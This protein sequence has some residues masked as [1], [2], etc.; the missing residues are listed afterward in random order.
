MRAW[1]LAAAVTALLLLP[2]HAPAE[3]TFREVFAGQ[4][5]P[6]LLVD[7]E[8]G[9]IV[10][11]NPAAVRFYQHPLEALRLMKIWDV[12]VLTR[13][14]IEDEMRLAASLG[15]NFFIFR[16][17]L[18]SG[19]VRSVAV[20]SHPY[21]FDGRELLLSLVFDV[22]ALRQSGDA[23]WHYQGRLEEQIAAQVAELVAW[24]RQWTRTLAAAVALQLGLILFLVLTIRKRRQAE[25]RRERL[26]ARLRSIN[27]E[28]GRLAEVTA[29]HFQE[30]ARRLVTFARSLR[31][32]L[33]DGP[34]PQEAESSLAFIEQQAIHLRSL[35]RDLQRFLAAG[36]P[37]GPLLTA[38][39]AA[40]LEEALG[41]LRAGAADADVA[42]EADA[43]P[44]LAIDPPRLR[45]LFTA[46]LANCLRFRHPDRPL[47]IRISVLRGSSRG[48]VE[49]AVADNGIG[50][51]AD[52]RERAFRLFEKFDPARRQEGTGIGLALARR[53][54]ASLDGA[55]R[56]GETPGG[57]TTVTFDLPSGVRQ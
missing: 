54:V 40:V 15:R 37:R 28:T 56:L 18:G 7:P 3:P 44:P 10:D 24:E 1:L 38:Q 52:Y 32:A 4:D 47:R 46:L 8:D 45:D 2:R 20:H 33:G 41:G 42:V 53:V 57:G 31:S 17:R 5:T 50:V 14:Q 25:R 21:G 12:N 35:T 22:T 23:L 6:M 51:P 29:H 19:E 49:I 13:S 11:A 55:V 9:A 39:P 27:E 30:P 34:M 48:R 26:V 36:Q 43:L 16:H